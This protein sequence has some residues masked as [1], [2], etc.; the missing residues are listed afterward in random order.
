MSPLAC[1]LQ[2]PCLQPADTPGSSRAQPLHMQAHPCSRQLPP[3][4]PPASR[5]QRRRPTA[6]AAAAAA[7]R[8]AAAAAAASATE[9]EEPVLSDPEASDLEDSGPSTSG[10]SMRHDRWRVPVPPALHGKAPR[11]HWNANA[12]AF[13]GD[14][15]WE[16]RRVLQAPRPACGQPAGEALAS[17][18]VGCAARQPALPVRP[19]CRRRRASARPPSPATARRPVPL[20]RQTPCRAAV[21]APSLLLPA[22]P[23]GVVLFAGGAPRAGRDAGGREG[24][25]VGRAACCARQACSRVRSGRQAQLLLQRA[26]AASI[27][28]AA[29]RA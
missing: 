25:A 2:R 27:P 24:P 13:L 16:V 14:S 9:D 1:S 7:G 17:T 21:R 22:L 12:L 19:N 28:A 26:A 18:A 8:A 3:L 10:G 4:P 23:Q 5:Q 15:V 11:R 20:L 29:A 6:R